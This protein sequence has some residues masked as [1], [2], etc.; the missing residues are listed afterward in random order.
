[1]LAL[2]GV[3]PQAIDAVTTPALW[4]LGQ[5]G[6]RAAGGGHADLPSTT[7]PGFAA[8]LTGRHG[9][10]TGASVTGRRGHGVR[11]TAADGHAVPGWAGERSVR[12]PTIL[13]AAH[14]AGLRAGAVLGDHHLHR[15]LRL[16]RLSL[17]PPKGRPP[18]G[19][20]LD[21]HGYPV[22]AAVREQALIATADGAWDLLFVHLNEVDTLGHDLGPGHAST[23]AGLRAADVVVAD[24]LQA[25]RPG[26]D[27]TVVIV[28]S[29]HG[30]D[31]RLPLAA[32]DVAGLVPGP[33]LDGWIGDGGAAWVRAR[34]PEDQAAIA[35]IL[36]S[37]EGIESVEL[38][39]HR[40][41]L[42]LAA[43]G[44]AFAGDDHEGGVH[45]ARST[46]RTLAI[47]G[48]GHPALEQLAP[49]VA[50]TTPHLADWAPAIESLLAIRDP[51]S[52]GLPTL[53]EPGA[54]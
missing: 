50:E 14:D 4:A 25:A 11:T 49:A 36:A 8:L 5:Q 30:M 15:V 35:G 16:G 42:A 53:L 29:D 10:R 24:L 18:R 19:T 47:V 17:W 43:P 39:G 41:I 3:G 7:Y 6:G 37:A 21:A 1:M 45:G 2:D 22:N 32:I 46:A 52:K 12:V 20:S 26:W 38:H 33:R 13:H 34:R 48:G 40:R 9:G 23:V 51:G 54:R 27:R 28:V 31:Q 44:R